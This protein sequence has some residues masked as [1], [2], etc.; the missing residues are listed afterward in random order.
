MMEIG[1]GR[2]LLGPRGIGIFFLFFPVIGPE[3][4]TLVLNAIKNLSPGPKKGVCFF[5]YLA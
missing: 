4:N 1:G 5:G 2:S 3:Q